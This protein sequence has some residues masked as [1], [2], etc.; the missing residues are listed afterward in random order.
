MSAT[1]RAKALVAGE[2]GGAAASVT[3][4]LAALLWSNAFPAAYQAARHARLSFGLG[5]GQLGLDLRTGID[6]GLMTS[7]FLLVGLEA[8]RELGREELRERLRL[9]L[10]V[11]AG[12]VAMA[13][14][15]GIY[16]AVNHTGPTAHGWGSAAFCSRTVTASSSH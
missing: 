1:N 5:S 10:P 9:L 6:S 14:P 16:L 2:A 7:P 13:L 3:A 4:L 15:V 11:G 12:V 8:R